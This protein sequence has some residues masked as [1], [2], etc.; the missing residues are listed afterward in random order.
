VY[1]A[2]KEVSENVPP[3]GGGAL[4]AAAPLPTLRHAFVL[5]PQTFWWGKASPESRVLAIHTAPNAF[6]FVHTTLSCRVVAGIAW[7]S[8]RA[9]RD[10]DE[11]RNLGRWDRSNRV[12]CGR[13]RAR[14]ALVEGYDTRA[15]PFTRFEGRLRAPGQN[16]TIG[17]RATG[18]FKLCGSSWPGQP[19]F[20][21]Q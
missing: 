11:S 9:A 20:V 18:G 7:A 2:Y 4:V 16:K 8:V 17:A 21:A 19:R 15:R 13:C 5:A 3:S 6:S 14:R 1:G 12:N 10:N